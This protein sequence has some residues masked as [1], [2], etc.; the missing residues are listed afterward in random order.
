MLLLIA[1]SLPNFVPP[2]CDF[3]LT[4][5]SDAQFGHSNGSTI[6]TQQAELYRRLGLAVTN[7]TVVNADNVGAGKPSK[8]TGLCTATCC[9]KT[10]D[11]FVSMPNHT[12]QSCWDRFMASGGGSKLDGGANTTNVVVI[13]IEACG[14]DC[15]PRHWWNF[16]D[17]ALA[18]VV[19]GFKRRLSIVRNSLPFAKLGLYGTTVHGS[20]G[21]INVSGYQRAAAMGVFDHVDILVP[22]LYLGS[23]MDGTSE[24]LYRLNET[25]KVKRKDGSTMPMWPNLRFAYVGG[26]KANW[27]VDPQKAYN[28]MCVLEQWDGGAGHVPIGG[29]LYWNGKDNQTMAQW[30]HDVNPVTSSSGAVCP[31]PSRA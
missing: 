18:E 30:F 12:I 6:Y 27:P 28:Q 31:R 1:L 5:E 9:V 22:V 3:R 23:S 20:G 16:T 24:S 2:V 29:V 26:K 17:E 21:G 14:G 25:S 19:D 11:D 7:S 10:V 15:H 4:F 13:D 8:S